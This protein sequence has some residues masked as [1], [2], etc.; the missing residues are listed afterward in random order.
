[1]K[2][3]LLQPKLYRRH[4]ACDLARDERL[5]AS[6]AFVVEQNP[7]ARGKPVTFAVVHRRPIREHLGHSVWTPRPEW[8]R[9]GLRHL[10]GFAKHLA[11]RCLVKLRADPGLA[12]RFQ[13]PDRAD[14]V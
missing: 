4:G 1:E 6:R 5:A 11:A 14:A 2:Q 13:N 7:V 9:L 8:R 10:L 12:D 3:L